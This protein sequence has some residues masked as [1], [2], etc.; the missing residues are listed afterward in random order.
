MPE[1]MRGDD[2][3]GGQDGSDYQYTHRNKRSITLNLKEP[4]GIAVLKKLVAK[5]D[6]VLENFR[7]DVKTRLGIDYETLSKVNPRLVYASISGFGQTGPYATRPGFDQ[8]AQGMGG[9]D[10]GDGAA[11][12]GPGA[13]GHPHRRSLRR[14]LR[15]VRRDRGAAR[16]RALGQGPVGADVAA[17]GDD[18]H[19]GFP[20]R[21]L[22]RSTARCPGR[23]A[24]STRP[25]S[26]PASTRRATATSTSRSSAARSG[27]ASAEA[28][29]A[30][31]WI[32]DE[33]SKTKSGALGE[34]RLAQ[35]RD[36]AAP[37][38]A[39]PATTG[40]RQLNEAGVACG[41]IN[42]MKE[43]FEEPQV[44]HLG[45][46]KEVV[47]PHLGEQTLVGQPVTLSRTPSHHRARDAAARRAH[48]GDPRRDSASTAR[49]RTHESRRSLS[50]ERHD[51]SL[52]HRA[53]EDLARRPAC[54]TSASTTR[55]STTRCRST[56]G[57]RCRR[58]SRRRESDDNVRMVVFSGEGEKAFVSGADISQFEDMRARAGGGEALRADGRGR[59]EGIYEF[60][61]PTLAC[62]RGYCIGGGVNVAISCDIRIASDDSV[63]SVPGRAPGPGLPL[64][65]DEEPGAPG[66][67]RAREGHLLHRRAA[68]T[69][70]R[71]SASAS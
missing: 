15:G 8:I 48:R 29:G 39:T 47:S 42:N 23:P 16:A 68:S 70:P 56:C 21:A 31:E 34:P 22:R 6:V 55:P 2:T 61:K 25:A 32:T 1:H 58:C 63:F 67:A 37:A 14:H 7:P 35:R 44:Q 66:R 52:H 54:C 38:C 24:T 30:P 4:Q 19:D 20:D 27:S 40:S 10:V 26:P 28:M 33:R 64:L 69:P 51:L 43:V 41:R 53:R 46:V 3:L 5:A 9:L 57:R 18:L 12:A 13:R 59:A 71:R 36:R 50:D 62:I 11:R 65:G 17:A 49:P 60:A 45:M